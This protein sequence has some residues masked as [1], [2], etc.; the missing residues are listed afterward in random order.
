MSKIIIFPTDTVYGIGCQIFD[1]EGIEKIYKIKKR[2][3]NKPLACLCSSLEQI[4]KIAIV[5]E[6]SM[7]LINEFMPGGLT[8]ILKAKKEVETKIGYKTIGVRIP[9]YVLAL[10]ILNNMGPMLVTSVNESGQVALNDYEEIKKQ[11]SAYVEEIY[12]PNQISSNI[13]STVIDMTKEELRILREGSIT[14]DDI[15]KALDE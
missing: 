2:D 12:P 15:K 1:V 13:A 7:K 5:D 6:T 11:Y 14:L 3:H 9:N 10:D 8:L 4:E